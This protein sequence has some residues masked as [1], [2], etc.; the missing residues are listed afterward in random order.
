MDRIRNEYIRGTAHVRCCGQ[1][2][3]E[4]GMRWFGHVQRRDREYI[5]RR[6]MGLELPGGLEEDQ[7]FIYVVKED[8]KVVGVREEHAEDRVRRRWMI[9]CPLIPIRVAGRCGKNNI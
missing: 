2:A 3:R 7:R 6:M 5:F 1:K 9:H 8:I 4:A